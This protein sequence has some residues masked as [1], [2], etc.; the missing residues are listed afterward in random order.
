MQEPKLWKI[1][2]RPGGGE[3]DIPS[4]ERVKFCLREK[5][6]GIGWQVDRKPSSK[7]DY[8]KLGKECVKQ[9]KWGKWGKSWKKNANVIL[10]RMKIGDL[11]WFRDTYDNYYLARITGEW[12]YRDNEEY[13]KMDIVNVRPVEVY[14]VG[15]GKRAEI[16]G[17]II[18]IFNR[19]LTTHQIH[20]ETALLF[21][22]ILFN[23]HSQKNYDNIEKK[24]LD[25]FSLL[26]SEDLEDVVGLYLQLEKKFVLIPSSRGRNDET[27]K[28]EFELM[29]EKGERAVVQVKS[30][31]TKINPKEY[32][33][34]TFKGKIFL[35]SP[36]GYEYETKSDTIETLSKSAIEEFL[37]EYKEKLPLKIKIWLD[38]LYAQK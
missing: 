12:E 20:D 17:K 24:S 31:N 26:S 7:E 18:S 33:K 4:E 37:K 25:I 21:S 14:K 27:L 15:K 35:F 38:Y 10:F 1:H 3:E 19:R 5:I 9:K 2:I 11:V 16:P 23:K 29:N 28:Y 32:E 36:A 8:M 30:G 34:E 6:I 13:K 22:K